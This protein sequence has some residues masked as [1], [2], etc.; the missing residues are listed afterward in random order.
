MKDKFATGATEKE[1]LALLKEKKRLELMAKLKTEGGPFT[2][3]ED[4]S[5]YME[6]EVDAVKQQKRLKM[7]VQFA[8]ESSKYLPKTDPL[9][10]IQITL[11]NKWRRDKTAEE[12]SIALKA[13]LGRRSD[14]DSVVTLEQFRASLRN[15]SGT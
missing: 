6:T 15:I 3:D 8:R 5:H 1:A 4:V 7:E 12:F 14:C 11:P 2:R 13:L 10:R 9:F